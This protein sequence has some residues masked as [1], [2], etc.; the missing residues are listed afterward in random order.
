MLRR[1]AIC[2]LALA[3]V[4]TLAQVRVATPSTASTQAE[5][6]TLERAVAMTLELRCEPQVGVQSRASGDIVAIS[7][8][9]PDFLASH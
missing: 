1:A 7:L 5:T 3:P 2:L 9:Y 6:S 4:L 8:T